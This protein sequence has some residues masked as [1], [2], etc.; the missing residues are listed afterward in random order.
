[1]LGV[2]LFM[3]VGIAIDFGR[4]YAFKSQLQTRADAAAMAGIV[5]VQNGKP[6]SAPNSAL[7]YLQLNPVEMSLAAVAIDTVEPGTYTTAGGFT[8]LGAWDA[9]VTAV[10]VKAHYPAA[11]TAARIFGF[12]TLLLRS[13][14]VA[15]QGYVGKTDCIKPIAMPY[16]QLLQTLGKDPANTAYDLTTAD[17]ARLATITQASNL[18]FKPGSQSTSN[19]IPGNFY[20]IDFPVIDTVNNSPIQGGGTPVYQAGLQGC[21]S[22]NTVGPG[23][24]LQYEQGDKAG[25]TKAAMQ[26]LCGGG[27]NQQFFLPCVN[28]PVP[29]KM[30][31]WDYT[32]NKFTGK[33][34]VHVKYIGAFAIT[35]YDGRG[36]LDDITGYF[37]SL[38]TTGTMTSTPGPLKMNGL[39]VE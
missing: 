33:D 11:Y 14:G 21:P 39:L 30:A 8:L 26:Q 19:G 13:V 32:T 27:G 35:G 34:A 18:T 1:M 17:I 36:Q 23:D 28:G 4:M 9:N 5:D 16:S 20:I 10:R 15:A 25:G 7:A 22:G 38:I 29:I 3:F 37:T 24:Y 2:V 6:T 31:I 12:D